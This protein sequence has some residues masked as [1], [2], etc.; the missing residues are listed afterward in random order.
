MIEQIKNLLQ[1][2]IAPQLEA[3]RGDIKALDVKVIASEKSLS[4]QITASEQRVEA[5]IA[6]VEQVFEAR[7]IAM[8]RPV[9]V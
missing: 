4:A 3:I 8:A 2:F 6:A 5:R 1:D 7:M 9:T